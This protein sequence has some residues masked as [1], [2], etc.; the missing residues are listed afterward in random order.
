MALQYVFDTDAPKVR[1]PLAAGEVITEGEFII[2]TDAGEIRQFDPSSD[3][4]PHGILVHDP[5]GDSIV[6]HDEDY[7]AYDELWTYRGDEDDTAYFTPLEAVDMIIPETIT[8]GADAN[9]NTPPEPSLGDGV[10][11]GIISDPDTGQTRVVESGFTFDVDNDG[12]AETFSESG[13]GDFVAIGRMSHRHYQD[14]LGD[15]YDQRISVRLDSDLFTP[16]VNN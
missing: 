12:T 9:G 13:A 10:T 2:H 7:V 4:L 6:D 1:K 16:S 3:P 11:V 8:S 5:A 14:L 15:N